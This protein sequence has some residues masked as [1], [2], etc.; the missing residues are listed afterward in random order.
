MLLDT[1][2]RDPDLRPLTEAEEAKT[3]IEQL[4]LDLQVLDAAPKLR[5][6]A[7]RRLQGVASRKRTA[8]QALFDACA[9][10]RRRIKLR[11]R[12]PRHTELRRLFGE[13]Y[14][15]S[16]AKPETVL[17][18]ADK[19]LTA[20]AA[21]PAE[22]REVRIG[23]PSI[24]RI[25]DL[26]KNLRD[27]RPQRVELRTARKQVC[28]DLSQVAQRVHDLCRSLGEL[29]QRLRPEVKLDAL[30]AETRPAPPRRRSPPAPDAEHR[31]PAPEVR[32][33]RDARDAR[34][35]AAA[36]PGRRQ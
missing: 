26:Q 9:K 18:F 3:I 19:V 6:G 31:A 34:S 22:L 23:P 13:G 1:V 12:G 27:T 25:A 15:A 2:Q 14:S 5:I 29:A 17:S 4:R 36:D 28:E 21:H 10:V 8:S 20:A 7:A 35:A 11:Y 30:L 16:P 33:V 32:D 24:K